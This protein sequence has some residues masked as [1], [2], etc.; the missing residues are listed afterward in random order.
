MPEVNGSTKIYGI[1]GE[2]IEHTLSPAIHNYLFE[3]FG[4][5]CIYVPF[6]TPRERFERWFPVLLELCEGL[7]ITI[8]YKEVSLNFLESVDEKA[9]NVGAVN[10][11]YR[12]RGFNT[13]YIAIK[14]LVGT[15]IRGLGGRV[16]FVFGAGGAAKAASI[17][18]AELGCTV[19]VVN[20]TPARARELVRRLRE[21]GY[22]AFEA[23]GCCSSCRRVLINATPNP[24]FVPESCI[25]DNTEL[26]IE[27][28]YRPVETSLVRKARRLSIPVI[29]GVRI[30]VRQAL[31][32]QKIWHGVEVQDEEVLG[33][34]Y[35]RKLLW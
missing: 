27:L 32:A 35:A 15:H 10:T 24:D 30:L 28:V 8:P 16:C 34:L 25:D 26:V 18:V 6:N 20:R 9:L 21:L 17:A 1:V 11:V 31:E 14:Q 23:T 3:K 12:G 13:D 7:N 2:G 29:D 4:L 22:E 5:N 33:F 19:A